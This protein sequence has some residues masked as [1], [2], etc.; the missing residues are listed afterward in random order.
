MVTEIEKRALELQYQFRFRL[1]EWA[2][3]VTDQLVPG[4][5]GVL[6][7]Y[8]GVY[9]TAHELA[10]KETAATFT[11]SLFADIKPDEI[12]SYVA[13]LIGWMFGINAQRLRRNTTERL[14]NRIQELE[15]RI[16]PH[17]TSSGLTQRG[18]TPKEDE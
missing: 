8:F 3:R 13:A 9:R 18:Q 5:I 16:D 14:T 10:G 7:I 15:A 1:I 17:R 4:A 11:A 12:I 6:I 2:S